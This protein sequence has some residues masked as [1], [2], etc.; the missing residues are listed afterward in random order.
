M[1]VV[2]QVPASDTIN[3]AELL[4][5]VGFRL[6][7]LKGTLFSLGWPAIARKICEASPLDYEHALNVAIEMEDGE[8]DAWLFWLKLHIDG[9][10]AG[11]KK[12]KD[13]YDFIKQ[14]DPTLEQLLPIWPIPSRVSMY[15]FV[16]EEYGVSSFYAAL[17]VQKYNEGNASAKQL[18]DDIIASGA[19]KAT[20][21]IVTDAPIVILPDL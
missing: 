2:G 9:K 15:E 14:F 1:A 5:Q 12:V 18:F 21:C 19:F 6:K 17:F 13:I 11:P 3:N 20:D 10:L 8:L 7:L 4:H 16:M